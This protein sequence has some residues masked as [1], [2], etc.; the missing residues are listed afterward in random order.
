[1]GEVVTINET[2]FIW[3]DGKPKGITH[4]VL[5]DAIG[6]D[7]IPAVVGGS[8]VKDSQPIG[9][10]SSKHIAS[11]PHTLIG[12]L[13]F[14]GWPIFYGPNKKTIV[15]EVL[16]PAHI[17][18]DMSA[19]KN[20][21]L[22]NYPP[23]RDVARMLNDLGC[24]S[25]CVLTSDAFDVREGKG[26]DEPYIVKGEDIGK[27]DLEHESLQTLW[28]WLPAFMFAVEKVG[29]VVM[30]VPSHG[31]GMESKDFSDTAIKS[32]LLKLESLG[33]TCTGSMKRAKN[34]YERATS[35][36]L[37]AAKMADDVITKMR[38]KTRASHYEGGMFG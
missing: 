33:F 36:T 19:Q 3:M 34:L 11:S 25:F 10:M 18:R 1:M 20:A 8:L 26:L 31:H 23:A 4:A 9:Y 12:S 6:S 37:E 28:G 22:F 15:I 16:T 35:D 29:A 7:H 24:K 17:S 2:D 21:W 38:N 27:D 30:I 32:T 14:T 13:G 5:F